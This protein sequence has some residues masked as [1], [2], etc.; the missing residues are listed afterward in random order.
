MVLV[1]SFAQVVLPND[2]GAA[3]QASTKQYCDNTFET[4]SAAALLAPLSSPTFT[5]L[6]T[7]VR[8]VK[9][10]QT[11][12]YAS[13]V[14][15]D[16]STGD[17]FAITATGD[18]HLAALTSPT[19][20]QMVVV[21]VLASGANRIVTIDGPTLLTTGLVQN[22]TVQSGQVGVFGFRYSVLRGSVWLLTSA[23]QG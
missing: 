3:L 10:P 21:E 4:Q 22:T 1:K 15:L 19:N 13:T 7:A 18:M 12:S 17:A 8:L 2:P 23:T 6:V 14:T 11:V 5:G 20:G 9:T 16:A